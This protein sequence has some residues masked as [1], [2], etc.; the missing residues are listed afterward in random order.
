MITWE[1]LRA[2]LNLTEEDEQAIAVERE[3]INIMIRIREA[4][5]LTQ[6]QVAETCGVK[7]SAIARW[8]SGKHSPRIDSLLK[9]LVP[10]GYTLQVVPI[11][12]K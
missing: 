6:E 3:L 5:G 4:K 12:K 2:S 11:V 8:E 7:Q 9:I 10:L 1:E